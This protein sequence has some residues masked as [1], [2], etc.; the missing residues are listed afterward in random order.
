[1]ERTGPSDAGRA[2]NCEH[3][4][5]AW[6]SDTGPTRYRFA[7]PG[8]GLRFANSPREVQA[9]PPYN[10]TTEPCSGS[11]RGSSRNGLRSLS[12]TRPVAGGDLEVLSDQPYH[13]YCSRETLELLS[14]E[15]Y[16]THG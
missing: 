3:I 4:S 1:M 15:T 7:L 14:V 2:A 8:Y 16:P 12:L 13:E 5:R 9:K 10:S 6:P 11:E